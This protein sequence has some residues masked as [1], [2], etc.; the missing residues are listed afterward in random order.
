MVK[1]FNAYRKQRI[2]INTAYSSWEE[3][4]FGVP[5]GSILGS[6]LFN[7]F[8]CD[9]F[10]IMNNVD[11][12]SY[13]DDNTPY[14]KENGV[15]EVINFLKEASG[16]LL[17][18]FADNQMK[19]NPDKYYS[20]TSSSDKVSICVDNYNIKS[21]KCEKLLDIKIDNK[22]NFNTHVD[23]ICKYVDM[24]PFMWTYSNNLYY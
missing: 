9:L 14:V 3:I 20:L 6:L 11:F 21:S 24:L 8:I 17:Y 7:I 16:E 5:Q 19:A 23:E 22:F 18:W 1:M 10:L 15:K 2:N 12:A 13:A 4:L